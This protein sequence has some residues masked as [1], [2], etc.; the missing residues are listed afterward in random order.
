MPSS[1]SLANVSRKPSERPPHVSG[2]SADS[3]PYR[4]RPRGG[5]VGST[6]PAP[7]LAPAPT[8]TANFV[9]ICSLTLTCSTDTNRRRTASKG[10]GN[11]GVHART[12]STPARGGSGNDRRRDERAGAFYLREGHP[13]SDHGGGTCPGALGLCQAVYVEPIYTARR[14]ISGLRSPVPET[15]RVDEHPTGLCA[16]NMRHVLRP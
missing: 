15:W 9:G 8:R 12:S 2:K 5:G 14:A 7:W 4:S 13:V 11:L 10:V 16:A 3:L 6:A 1:T